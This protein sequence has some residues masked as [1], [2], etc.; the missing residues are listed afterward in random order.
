[1]R[2][3]RKSTFGPGDWKWKWV[4][5]IAGLAEN[6]YDLINFREFKLGKYKEGF[7]RINYLF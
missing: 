6:N 1:M 5:F 2:R 7:F 4:H 3:W